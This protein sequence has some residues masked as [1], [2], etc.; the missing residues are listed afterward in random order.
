[1]KKIVILFFYVLIN[2]F[3]LGQ[4]IANYKLIVFSGS[5]WC[6]PCIRL[7]SETLNNEHTLK[8]FTEKKVEIYTAD[9][10]RKKNH[11]PSKEI[12]KKNEELAD[13][14]NSDGVFPKLVL[15][16]NNNNLIYVKEGFIASTTLI[17]ELNLIL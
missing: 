9:F 13:L 7:K 8:F 3:V 12:V 11:K 16:D 14:Y 17:E 1:M 2:Q 10:P 15:L 4:D 6:K 5:D